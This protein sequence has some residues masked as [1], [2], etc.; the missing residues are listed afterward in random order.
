MYV[1]ADYMIIVNADV[2]WL[3]Y[4]NGWR[5]ASSVHSCSVLIQSHFQLPPLASLTTK[6]ELSE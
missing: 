4:L 6:R 5:D 1:H 3:V 2:H